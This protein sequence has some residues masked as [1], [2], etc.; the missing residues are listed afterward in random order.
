MVFNTK[1]TTNT[2]FIIK[3]IC[4]KI[5][6]VIIKDMDQT[7]EAVKKLLDSGDKILV[8][9][10]PSADEATQLVMLAL[11]EIL[12]KAGK[13]TF[14]WPDCGSGFAAKFEKII[15]KPSEYRVPQKIKIKIPKNIPLDELKY[16]EETGFFSIII[17][18]KTELEPSV[19]SIEKSPHD[20]DAAFCFFSAQ[21][22]GSV[23]NKMSAPVNKPPE[24][25]T[26]YFVNGE[27]T[28]AEKINE[29]GGVLNGQTPVPP[30]TASLIMA[31]LMYETDN[32]QKK[33]GE[34]VFALASRLLSFG[35]DKKAI[36]EILNADKKTGTAQILGRALARTASDTEIKTS[37]TFLTKHDFE[38][39][40]VEPT[41]E[42]SLSILKKVRANIAPHT[43][44]VLCREHEDGVRSL[45][46]HE[47]KK[48][49]WGLAS[50]LGAVIQ[51]PYFFASGFKN[52]SEAE[53]KIRNL[54]REKK[55][56]KMSA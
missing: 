19:I 46:F 28:L 25:K 9:G 56:D 18:P 4:K 45:I 21:E 38:K 20:I 12:E 41:D 54:L 3:N 37:W 35:A 31:S 16:E 8:A 23:W 17:S 5:P 27:K 14:L 1:S 24:G 15:P 6:V 42:N 47:D 30:K 55:S 2:Q 32:F 10:E 33:S 53:V 43:C 26:G 13:K 52:F 44:S 49:L 22:I 39:T 11:R 34:G 36:E 7:Q 29:I 51:S 48:A 40:G 50:S